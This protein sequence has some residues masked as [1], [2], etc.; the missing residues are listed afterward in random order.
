ME[1]VHL[2]HVVQ[3]ACAL[4]GRSTAGIFVVSVVNGLH[5]RQQELA[6]ALGNLSM[7]R[8]AASLIQKHRPVLVYGLLWEPKL[9]DPKS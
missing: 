1:H 9:Q 2:L 5:H 7:P 8:V 4:A 3:K 6:A